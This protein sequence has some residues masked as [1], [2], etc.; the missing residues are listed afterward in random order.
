M[1]LKKILCLGR[2]HFEVVIKRLE[3]SA[4]QEIVSRP[5][6]VS[7]VPGGAGFTT[8]AILQKLGHDVSVVGCLGMD[9]QGNALR[10][11]LDDASLK[12]KLKQI[13]EP[14]GVNVLEVDHVGKVRYIVGDAADENFSEF[15]SCDHG[16]HHL[17]IGNA[18]LFAHRHLREFKNWLKSFRELN[19]GATISADSTKSPKYAA[20]TWS[21]VPLVDYYLCNESEARQATG[22]R[23]TVIDL[24]AKLF[25]DR[26][27]GKAVIIKRAEKG[28]FWM[29]STD[30]GSVKPHQLACDLDRNQVSSG[31]AFCAGFIDAILDNESIDEASKAGNRIAAFQIDQKNNLA[32]QSDWNRARVHTYTFSQLPARLHSNK[33]EQGENFDDHRKISDWLM[34][35][36]L[37]R[38]G[39]SC[40]LS[41][42]SLVLD[43]GCGTGRFTIPIADKFDCR[44]IGIDNNDQ[45]LDL[46]KRK[47]SGSA[48]GIE[49]RC[50]N[51]LNLRELLSDRIGRIDC[52]WISSV[53]EELSDFERASLFS[54]CRD[55]LA[56]EGRLLVRTTFAPLL[57][58]IRFFEFFRKGRDWLAQNVPTITSVWKGL[59]DCDLLPM[60]IEFVDDSEKMPMTEMIEKLRA[61]VY[62]WT[63]LYSDEEF[64]GCVKELLNWARERDEK[65]C[66]DARP[67]YFVCAKKLLLAHVHT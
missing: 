38:I 26:G 53:L 36:W 4:P 3:Y 66:V 47:C 35:R 28:V 9:W 52:I 1:D 23:A 24:V 6:S 57:E 12:L 15:S 51:I 39:D 40:K 27:V 60:K 67:T 63:K 7:I 30:H 16:F 19:P 42:E 48:S 17:H 49:W 43:I 21:V 62:T 37:R 32:I 8:S 34:Q 18:N 65:V 29:D 56:P 25:I 59:Q 44:V 33:E 22:R 5:Q 11:L 10:R 54:Q 13:D 46:A 55:L 50:G 20:A 64:E 45:W 31:D 14:T 58:S 2:I 41:A 61:R